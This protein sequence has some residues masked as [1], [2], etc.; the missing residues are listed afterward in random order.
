MISRQDR[1]WVRM[2][3]AGHYLGC[4]QIAERSFFYKGY[5]FPVC[6]RCTGVFASFPLSVIFSVKKVLPI[7][8]CIFMSLIMLADWLLQFMNIKQSTN[9]RRLITGFIGGLGFHILFIR[10]IVSLFERLAS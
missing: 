8:L 9:L 2:M 5:Q 6:A 7:F 4:H 10:G 1:R 3:K